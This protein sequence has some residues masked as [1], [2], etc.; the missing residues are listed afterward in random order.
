[1]S[2]LPSGPT[3]PVPMYILLYLYPTVWGGRHSAVG[4]VGRTGW[5]VWF[6]NSGKGEIVRTRP[7]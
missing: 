7:D 6:S 1:M 2:L 5:T 3:W 4:I